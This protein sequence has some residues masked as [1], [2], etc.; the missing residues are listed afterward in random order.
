MMKILAVGAGGFLG[1]IARWTLSNWVQNQMGWSFPYGTLVVNVLGCLAI[2]AVAT[3]IETAAAWGPEVRL[4]LTVGILGSFTTFS[5]L[6]F[7]AFEFLRVG[8][9]RAALA[10]IASNVILGLLAVWL[11]RAAV[12]GWVAWFAPSA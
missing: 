7:E 4:L 12:R 10:V 9:H 6:G 3:W 1:A 11:G 2:G 5:T 8:S